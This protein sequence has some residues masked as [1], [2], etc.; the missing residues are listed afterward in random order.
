M[1]RNKIIIIVVAV[2][3]L[4]CLIL[5]VKP[6]LNSLSFNEK[7]FAIE[8]TEKISKVILTNTKGQKTELS[9]E[10]NIWMLNHQY[11][12]REQVVLNLLNAL[13]NIKAD[14]PVSKSGHN[15]VMKM[16]LSN[17][18]KVEVYMDDDTQASKI[19]YVG[20]ANVTGDGTFM[21]LENKGKMAERPYVTKMLGVSG[22]LT[23]YFIADPRPWRSRE[24]FAYKANEIKNI[25]IKYPQ[26]MD[27]SFMIDNCGKQPTISSY[28]NA[29][30]INNIP[31]DSARLFEYISYY[32]KTFAE[33]YI[34][35]YDNIDTTVNT[36][37]YCIMT[38]TDKKDSVNTLN[39]YRMPTTE[40][41]KTQYDAAGNKVPYDS[42]KFIGLIN[43]KKD[44]VL[45]QYYVFGKYFK[46]YEQFFNVPFQ[47]S[48]V[49]K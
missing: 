35:E 18:T 15:N 37:P 44:Y 40:R 41:T 22:A 11:K 2:L 16:L 25:S 9:K 29:N 49:K 30:T 13:S 1:T 47:M 7:A 39:I 45:I 5:F 33:N 48:P 12:A 46:R 21:I 38:I 4:A 23:P 6:Y 27:A 42:D 28:N 17:N 19:F 3:L 32:E 36:T 31:A 20:G 8:H 10:N 26:N 34:N 14:Y 43:D 24:I